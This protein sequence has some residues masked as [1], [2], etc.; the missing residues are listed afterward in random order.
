MK[1]FA[2][3]AALAVGLHLLLFSVDVDRRDTGKRDR[4]QPDAMRID[5][6]TAPP[7]VERPSPP[8]STLPPTP[9]IPPEG[10]AGYK[11]PVAATAPKTAAGAPE[12]VP[13]P[14][15]KNSPAAPASPKPEPNAA[16]ILPAEPAGQT[17]SEVS[18]DESPVGDGRR[19]A[20]QP[21]GPRPPAAAAPS[22]A[23]RTAPAPALQAATPDY[24]RNPPPEYPRRARQLGFEGAVLLH[25]WVNPSGE[26]DHA[27]I[28]ASSGYAVLDDSALRAVKGWRFKP[29]RQGGQPVAA[30]VQVPVRFALTSSATDIP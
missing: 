11:E 4:L 29:A 18:G 25:V 5:L 21:A 7:R 13:R 6:V 8:S 2:S 22:E 28:A 24:D 19:S 16:E 14:P 26:V 1:R 17:S 30:L 23:S 15:R 10:V 9:L 20:G 12:K 3:A 27:E